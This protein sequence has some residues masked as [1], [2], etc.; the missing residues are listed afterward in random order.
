MVSYFNKL[1][2]SIQQGYNSDSD[3]NS[4]SN[5]N[6]GY[7]A[8]CSAMPRGKKRKTTAATINGIL[9][10]MMMMMM[11]KKK[12]KRAAP[13]TVNGETSHPF[14][15]FTRQDPQSLDEAEFWLLTATQSSS[16]SF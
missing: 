1:S 14:H 13:Y 9:K 12:G 15:Q 10:V 5:S 16:V 7:S 2:R 3:Q 6:K 4:D 11:K 8:N